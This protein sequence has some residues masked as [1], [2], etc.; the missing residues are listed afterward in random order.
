VTSTETIAPPIPIE[1]IGQLEE[2]LGVSLSGWE[3]HAPRYVSPSPAEG[4]EGAQFSVEAVAK[5]I[6]VLRQLPHTKGRWGGTPFEPEPWQVVWII[7]PVFGWL[8]ESGLRIVREVWFEVP[9]KAGKSTIAARFGIVLLSADGE[10]GAEVYAAATSTE[11]AR[12]VHEQGKFVVQ[13]APASIKNRFQ[14][15]SDLIRYPKTYGI[16][17]VLSKLAD[18]AHGLNVSGAVIDEVHL[19]KDRALID[20]IDTGTAAREQP[21]LIYITT[22]GDEDETTIYA[23]KHNDAIAIAKGEDTDPSIWVVIWAADEDADPFAEETWAAA[24]PNYPQTPSREY[25]EKKA[26]K[27]QRTPTFLPTFKRL[28][29]NIRGSIEGQVWPGS[30]FWDVEGNPGLVVEQKLK[31]KPAWGGVVATSVTDLTAIAWLFKNPEGAGHWALWRWFLPEASLEGLNKRT[32]D[33]ADLWVEERRLRLTPGSVIDTEAH[34]EQI[35]ADALLFDMRELVFDATSTIGIMSPLVEI[36]DE[37]VISMYPTHPSSALLDWEGLLASG[38][39]NHGGD[40]IATWQVSKVWVREAA[41]GVFKIDRK[42]S[43]EN[44]AGIAAAELAL[45]RALQPGEPETAIL[46]S[47]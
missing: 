15:L 14:V 33:H 19:H 6:R 32:N 34:I 16:F 5:V 22:A 23:E 12:Q 36:F 46:Q 20:A 2:A 9:R 35:K 8:Y 25:L 17:R 7:A 41:T 18:V 44:V 27:A 31:G 26:R 37:R 11:Q 43:P 4:I 42:G 28:H 30:A 45:R 3:A 10:F 39:F 21:L 40:P 1:A 29:L 38:E 24:N 47:V 13:A